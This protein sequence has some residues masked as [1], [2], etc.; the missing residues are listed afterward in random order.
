MDLYEFVY[1][2]MCTC[3]NNVIPFLMSGARREMYSVRNTGY[4]Q[5][6]DPQQIPAKTFRQ[7][8]L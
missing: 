5:F 3:M 1:D 6:T 2:T 8:L 7:N 4:M